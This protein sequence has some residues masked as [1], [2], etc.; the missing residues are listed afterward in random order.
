[1]LA[2]AYVGHLVRRN[3]SLAT[4]VQ[5]TRHVDAFVVFLALRGCRT[6][7]RL[8]PEDLAAFEAWLLRRRVR[9]GP[10][11]GMRLV[12]GSL[13]A[14]TNAIRGFLQWLARQGH[15]LLD[16]SLWLTCVKVSRGLPRV[17]SPDEVV[18]LLEATA[19][20]QPID[21]RD[22]AALELLYA[23]GLRVGEM[24]HLDLADL[25]LLAGEGMV[26]HG[27]GGRDRRALLGECAVRALAVYLAS[28]RESLAARRS[29]APSPAVFLSARGARWSRLSAEIMLH[30][31]AARAGLHGRVTPHVLRHTAA[32]HLLLGGADVRHVQ[33]FLGHASVETTTWYTALSREELRAALLSAH[34]RSTLGALE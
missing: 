33:E 29:G 14:W 21:L 11:K 32:V 22:R 9:V 19:G 18:R 34:P 28:G 7:A 27:K 25:D 1:V 5:W 30:R 23:S 10:R 8:G 17:L 13:A 3:L 2:E 15:T 4:R 31:R 26:R 6:V 12:P 20:D 16:W 24:V